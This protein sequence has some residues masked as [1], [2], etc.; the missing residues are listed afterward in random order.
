MEGSFAAGI[1]EDVPPIISHPG[2]GRNVWQGLVTG[3]ADLGQDLRRRAI[4]WKT[5]SIAIR[6]GLAFGKILTVALVRRR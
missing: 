2:G 5:R 3:E 1:A 6:I 4:Q